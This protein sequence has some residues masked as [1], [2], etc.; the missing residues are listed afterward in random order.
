[1]STMILTQTPITA[2]DAYIGIR[3][4]EYLPIPVH[5][6][7]ED[8]D[9]L[10]CS[11]WAVAQFTLHLVET[12]PDHDFQRALT[13]RCPDDVAGFPCRHCTPFNPEGAALA[14]FADLTMARDN[15]GV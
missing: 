4:G 10:T 7:A 6:T 9:L 15:L 14:L 5:E 13:G 3:A 1:M 11:R 2:N 12:R 8:R